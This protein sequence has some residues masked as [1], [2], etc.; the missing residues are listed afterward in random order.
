[1]RL[2]TV[3]PRYLDPKGLVAVWREGLLAQKVLFGGTQ[4]YRHHPQL[5]R[6]RAQAQPLSMIASYLSAIHADSVTRGY[7][8]DRTKIVAEP[9]CETIEENEGQVS[10]EWRHL[11]AKLAARS[12]SLYQKL[13]TVELPDTHPMF[14]VVPGPKQAWER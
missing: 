12:P 10:F 1:M 7:Q 5:E 3:H 11:L 9:S 8:F 13:R 14:T 2:W 4:G 6:F